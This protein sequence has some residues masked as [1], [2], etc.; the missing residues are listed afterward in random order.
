MCRIAGLVSPRLTPADALKRVKLM[1]DALRHGGPDDEGFFSDESV[2]LFFGNRRLSIIDLSKN[3]HQP[4][5]DIQQRV[6]IT[7]NGEIYNYPELK[8]E[9]LTLGVRFHSNTD[10]EV[11]INAYIKWGV[12]AF[13][14]FRGAC[15]PL[16]F[17]IKPGRQPIWFAIPRA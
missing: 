15:L 4:M 11:I 7:F 13:S 17:M 9:L 12:A 14:K 5:A 3:G 1:C 6:W 10:T 16:P 8:E 2:G